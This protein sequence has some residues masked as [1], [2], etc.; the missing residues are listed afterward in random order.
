MSQYRDRAVLQPP[1]KSESPHP[2]EIARKRR[3]TARLQ[4]DA[5][6]SRDGYEQ[7]GSGTQARGQILSQSRGEWSSAQMTE[8]FRSPSKPT[9]SGQTFKFELHEK[10][11]S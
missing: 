8:P 7:F 6:P 2:R 11:M 9:L 5:R 4:T 10:S 1:K 3:S